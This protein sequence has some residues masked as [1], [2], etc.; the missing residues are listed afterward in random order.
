MA[1]TPPKSVRVVSSLDRGLQVLQHI[2]SAESP[3]RLQDI[4]TALAMDKGAVY[5]FLATL[6]H[7]GL[8]ERHPIYKTYAASTQLRLW[9]RNFQHNHAV[10]DVA[11]PFMRQL[12]EQTGH[13][14]HVAILR[15]DRVILVEVLTGDSPIAV[16]QTAGDWDPLFCSAVGKAML[17]FLPPVEQR[18]LING[19]SFRALSPNTITS[20]DLL[21]VELRQVLRSRI[22]FDDAEN[23]PQI[24]CIAAPLLDRAGYPIA[25]I[26]ISMVTAHLPGG[27]RRAHALIEAVHT[28]AQ[29]IIKTLHSH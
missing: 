14:A 6:L 1:S 9:S 15:E 13:T 24:S 2:V 4:V 12:A 27:V 20:A 19:I 11:R 29:A 10:V 21:R 18:K 5:R 22:A 23:N 26:G 28:A 25:S 8:I 17:A 3:Q 7:R 16:R